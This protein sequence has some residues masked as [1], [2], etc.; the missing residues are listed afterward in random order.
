M[1]REWAARRPAEEK[2]KVKSAEHAEAVGKE[3]VTRI[4]SAWDK[5]AASIIET[6]GILNEVKEDKRLIPHGDFGKWVE[7]NVEIRWRIAE[8][9]MV[10]HDNAAL[11]NPNNCSVLPAARSTLYALSKFSE[12]DLEEYIKQGR[13]TPKM[14]AKEVALLGVDQIKQGSGMETTKKL[15]ANKSSQDLLE[16]YRT[17]NQAIAQLYAPDMIGVLELL[18]SVRLAADV[19]EEDE[20]LPDYPGD[21]PAEDTPA[22]DTPAEK[23]SPNPPE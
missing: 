16:Q 5:T 13:I 10:I 17:E 3:Y 15:L 18:K 1:E 21:S 22:E 8:Y 6:G 19:D 20:D 23:T 7:A 12:G 2:R 14:T 11:R 4:E 9:L